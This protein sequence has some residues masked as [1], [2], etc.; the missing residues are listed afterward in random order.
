MANET[1][2]TIKGLKELDD[3]LKQ[4]PA[5]IEANLMR[6]AMRSGLKEIGGIAKQ[7]LAAEGHVQSG[8]LQRSIKVTFDKKQESKYGWMRGKLVAGNKKAWYAHIIEFGSGMFYVG[9]GA[10]SKR[11]AY[12]IKAKNK[13]ALF[14]GGSA[15]ESVMHPGVKP[16]PFMRPALDSGAQRA[17][18]AVA[19]YLTK[20]IPRTIK[21]LKKN[22]Y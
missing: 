10:K 12:V 21:K 20:G 14:F 16:S 8:D 18:N 22:G 19:A 13:K 11:A 17:I 5:E 3:L 2:V 9:K 4:L 7:M 6:A 1:T 15:I